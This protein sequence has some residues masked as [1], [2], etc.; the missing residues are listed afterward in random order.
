MAK[1]RSMRGD[2]IDM[3][4]LKS[5]HEKRPAIGNAMMNARGDRLGRDGRVVKTKEQAVEEYYRN[6]PRAVEQ[7]NV[8]LRSIEDEI[9]TPAEMLKKAEEL[10]A[11]KPLAPKK[12][13]K[14]D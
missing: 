12:K 14:F 2:I 5:K 3:N 6:N 10:G 13:L 1:I 11:I 9:M 8:P 7:A 4:G